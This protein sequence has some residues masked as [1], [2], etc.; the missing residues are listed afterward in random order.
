M[1][2]THRLQLLAIATGSA[3]LCGCYVPDPVPHAVLQVSAAGTYLLDGSAIAAA[4]LPAALA[5]R[6]A[7]TPELLVEISASPQASL[8]SVRKAMHDTQQ[9]RLRVAFAQEKPLK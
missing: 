2:A 6:Q 4:D 7:R 8:A 9:A 5:R 1:R 3:L